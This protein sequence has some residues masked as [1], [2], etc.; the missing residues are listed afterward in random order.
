MAEEREDENDAG[1]IV[2]AATTGVR[3]SNIE[4]TK[5]ARFA[6]LGEAPKNGKEQVR[7]IV[8]YCVLP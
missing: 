8:A 4:R 2:E 5:F 7:G 3:R 1:S 6:R